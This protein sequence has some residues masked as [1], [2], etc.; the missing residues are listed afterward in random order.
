[1]MGSESSA[2]EVF[3]RFFEI[4]VSQH[5]LIRLIRAHIR[6][7]KREIRRPEA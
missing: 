4:E 7:C 3:F 6:R 1:M 2:E 5:N